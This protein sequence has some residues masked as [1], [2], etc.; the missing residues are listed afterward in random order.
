MKVAHVIWSFELGGAEA[1]MA[2]IINRQVGSIDVV[3][4]VVNA[5]MNDQLLAS[6]DRRVEVELIKRPPRSRN[7]WHLWKLVR[8]LLGSAP[9]IVHVHNASLV[10][11]CSLCRGKQLLTV[12]DTGL[13]VGRSALR[14]DRVV[15]ISEA[16]AKDLARWPVPIRSVVIHNG[17][18]FSAI[19]VRNVVSAT[20]PFRLVQVSRLLADKKG[21]DLLLHAIGHV[22][23]VL[24]PGMLLVD[25][26]GA[27]PDE[28]LLRSMAADLGVAHQCRFLGG[29]RRE[30]VY[31]LLHRYDGLAQPSRYEGFGLTVVEGIAAGLPVAAAALEGPLEILEPL[32]YRYLFTPGDGDDLARQLV[33]MMEDSTREG[34]YDMLSTNRE[35]A[36][37]RFDVGGTSNRYES[38]YRQ[39][40]L[41]V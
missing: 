17:V 32:P 4:V 37:K 11:I 35:A 29:M 18:D 20:R 34:F 14:C 3:L 38:E 16:V 19:P 24:G 33:H 21:Q 26:I 23:R 8:F 25:F 12:H 9:D 2:D 22:N 1:M 6:I 13:K 31:R 10:S 41:K 30:K 27:G 7:P 40:L 15:S 28:A 36:Q 5:V 39:L